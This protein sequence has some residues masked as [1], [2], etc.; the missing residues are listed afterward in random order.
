MITRAFKCTCSGTPVVKAQILTH[1]W[2]LWS[3][4]FPPEVSLRTART[5]ANVRRLT[6]Y[7]RYM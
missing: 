6:H 7:R 4:D 5:W 1:G 3:V 2:V